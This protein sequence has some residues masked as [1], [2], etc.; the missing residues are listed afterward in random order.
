MLNLNKEP[1]TII[2]ILFLRIFYC[3]GKAL[4]NAIFIPAIIAGIFMGIYLETGEKVDTESSAF[5]IIDKFT[6]AL[7]EESKSMWQ[8]IRF[9]L[10][11]VSIIATAVDIYLIYIAGIPSIITAICGYLGM[12]FIITGFLPR[13]GIFVLVIGEIVCLLLPD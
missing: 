9:W 4:Y 10:L 2:L 8:S 11:L 5:M 13:L 1:P 12:I 7:G 6:D 3:M